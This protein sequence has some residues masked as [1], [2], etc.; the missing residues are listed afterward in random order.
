M[1]TRNITIVAVIGLAFLLAAPAAT[2]D[3]LKFKDGT[4]VDGVIK[5]VEQGKVLVLVGSED[6]EFNI[7]DIDSMDFT[8]P[9]LTTAIGDVPVEHFLK[10]VEAQEVVRNFEQL[11]KTEA[12]VRSM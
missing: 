2:A 8:T 10:D 4:Y 6:K 12:E 1:W 9:H 5:R 7:L 11:E 3:M